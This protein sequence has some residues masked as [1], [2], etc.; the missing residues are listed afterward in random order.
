[1]SNKSPSSFGSAIFC[2]SATQGERGKV[3][4][5]G[6]FTSFL[7]WA[8]P[9]SIRN[10]QA[11]VT[12]YNLPKE[13]T[14]VSVAIAYGRGKKETLATADVEKGEKELGNV[15]HIPL[16][17]QFH[18][19]GIYNIFFNIIGT[20]KMLKVPLKVSTQDWPE[21]TQG[22]IEL[23]RKNKK[24]PNT[25]RANL[26]CSNCSKPYT[27]EEALLPGHKM[28]DGV[29]PFPDSGFIIC[30]SCRRKIYLK[31]VQGQ[32]RSS[33]KTAVQRARKGVE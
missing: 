32:V 9:T 29:Q 31:D 27:F 30:K 16:R 25:I 23:I 28:A 14:T 10:W 20:I 21:F 8:Y 22:E 15:L 33:M 7:A 5:R 26:T 13:T 3:D 6:I 19:E 2:N 4:C 17:Y 1:M 24:M 11:I 18:R 12:I